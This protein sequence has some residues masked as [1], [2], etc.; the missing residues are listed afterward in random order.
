MTN[1]RF[2]QRRCRERARPKSLV[3]LEHLKS[4]FGIAVRALYGSARIAA[5]LEADADTRAAEERQLIDNLLLWFAREIGADCTFQPGEKPEKLALQNRADLG[6]ELINFS[7][8]TI[9]S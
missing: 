2:E 5:K 8:L 3:S 6:S 1:R 9:R 4:A 7:A